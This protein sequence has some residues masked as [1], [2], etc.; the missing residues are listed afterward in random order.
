MNG[1]T[2]AA[3]EC[4]DRGALASREVGLEGREDL[5]AEAEGKGG[6]YLLMA[7]TTKCVYPGL[8]IDPQPRARVHTCAHKLM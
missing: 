6:L 1:S 4:Q 8:Q 7:E 5:G 3:D 2:P